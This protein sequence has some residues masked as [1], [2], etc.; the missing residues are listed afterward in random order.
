LVIE[1]GNH[2]FPCIGLKKFGLTSMGER[3]GVILHQWG[4]FAFT[5]IHQ[6]RPN[7]VVNPDSLHEI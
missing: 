6:I 2:L 3:N 4:R 5:D 1:A 7:Q